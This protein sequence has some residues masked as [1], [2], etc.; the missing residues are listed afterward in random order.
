MPGT[1]RGPTACGRSL[2]CHRERSG[3]SLAY[4]LLV[5][6]AQNL[7]DWHRRV[8]QPPFV[9]GRPLAQRPR[10]RTPGENILTKIKMGVTRG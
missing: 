3:F 8:T 5:T 9:T 4:N 1:K 6:I 10:G 7:A 2:G